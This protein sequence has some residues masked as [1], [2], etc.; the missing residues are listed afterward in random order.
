MSEADLARM[1]LSDDLG[2][3]GTGDRAALARVYENTSSKLFGIVLRILH[4]REASEDV[5]QDVYLKIWN[6]AQ[7]F[8]RDRA[9]PITWMATIARNSAIDSRR[10]RD[11][12][13]EEPEELI[14]TAF[15]DVAAGDMTRTQ[16]DRL[17]LNECMDELEE[18][19]RQFIR[20]AFFDGFTYVE[21]A[22]RATVPLG[23]MKSWIRRG[24]E[25]LKRCLGDD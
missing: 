16:D 2:R 18:H 12:R 25:R 11:R 10:T 8:D 1:R 19:Q 5:L 24:L 9:S 15:A 14:Q 3:V 23:T 22:E 17:Q 4:D 6:R 20:S 21:L 7:A 13:Q